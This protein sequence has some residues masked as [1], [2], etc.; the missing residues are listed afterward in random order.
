[1]I[2]VEILDKGYL[3]IFFGGSLFIILNFVSGQFGDSDAHADSD[4]DAHADVDVDAHVD[5]DVDV[6]VDV[7]VEVDVDMDVDVDAHVD[8]DAHVEADA[9]VDAHADADHHSHHGAADKFDPAVEKKKS[10]LRFILGILSPTNMSLAFTGFGFGGHF[11]MKFFPQLGILTLIPAIFLGW[12][13]TKVFKALISFCMKALT[14]KSPLG[15]E[16]AIGYTG[17]VQASIRPGK[18]GQVTYVLQGKIFNS[19]AKCISADMEIPKGSKVLIL[20]TEGHLVFVEPYKENS[21]EEQFS[22]LK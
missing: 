8:A 20:K 16:G 21:L 6:E 19:A 18:V 15:K 4:V 2:P 14:S 11:A 10:P 3:I 12:L 1:M 13:F 9:D 7:E 5:T 22:A 17:E